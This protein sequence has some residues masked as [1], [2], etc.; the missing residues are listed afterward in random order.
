M[1]RDPDEVERRFEAAMKEADS[2]EALSAMR[3]LYDRS[4]RAGPEAVS[5][6]LHPRFELRIEAGP[7]EGR[8][9]RGLE[10]L[11]QARRDSEEHFASDHFEPQGI[12]GAPG[13]RLV[14]LGRLRVTEK[15][16]ATE[17]DVPRAHV[18]ELRDGKFAR[19]TVHG[20]IARALD[21]VGLD[22]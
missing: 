19:V 18:C 8:T 1:M 16:G 9:Y 4:E 20:D 22:A 12:R 13:G 3:R 2:G 10:G 14:V 21:A 17:L 5:D 6:L 7:L 15:E 11:K